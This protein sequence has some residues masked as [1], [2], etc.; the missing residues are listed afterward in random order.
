MPGRHSDRQRPRRAPARSP[1]RNRPSTRPDAPQPEPPSWEPEL[2]IDEG[3]VESEPVAD[4][5]GRN[6]PR[7]GRSAGTGRG[8]AADPGGRPP[9]PEPAEFR[10]GKSL[11]ADLRAAFADDR[12]RERAER[13]LKAATEDFH[14]GRFRDARAKLRPLAEQAP[15]VAAVRELHGLTLYRLGRWKLAVREL[16]AFRSLTGSVEQDPVLA[17]CYRGLRRYDRVQELWREL[18]AARPPEP[19]LMEGRIVVA[20]ALADQ[21]RL[22]DA[23]SLLSH[24]MGRGLRTKEH[25]LRAAYAL[26]D[27]YERAGDLP[28]ARE[29]FQRIADYDPQFVDV[30]ARLAA[31]A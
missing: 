10:R 14:H 29:L 17:D 4:L 25:H 3:V 19:L 22:S 9:G 20:G 13:T 26:A 6:T 28:Q 24:S 27:L 21:G 16:E 23:I 12:H 31:L 5:R 8:G 18:R 30:Q 7:A 2:W 1:R 11:D 15:R